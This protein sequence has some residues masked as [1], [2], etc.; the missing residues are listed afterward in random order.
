MQLR[1]FVDAPFYAERSLVDG[2]F[3]TCGYP[4]VHCVGA[5][6]RSDL[7]PYLVEAVGSR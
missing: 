3:V 5:G 2:F 4:T 1:T 6:E 7:L